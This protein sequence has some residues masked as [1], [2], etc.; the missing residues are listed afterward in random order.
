MKTRIFVTGASGFIGRNLVS[1]L[2]AHGYEVVA[3]SRK[4]IQIEG[5]QWFS[6]DILDAECLYRSMQGCSCVIHLAAVTPYYKINLS[7]IDAFNNYIQGIINIITAFDKVDAYT[8]LFASSGKVYGSSA[9]VPFAEDGPINPSS[10]MGKLKAEAERILQLYCDIARKNCRIISLR[11]FNA[12]GPGQSTDFLIPKLIKHLLLGS[13]K[14][15]DISVKRDYIHID[16]II[17][18]IIILL[19]KAPEGFIA[20]NVGSGIAISIAEIIEILCSLSKKSLKVEIDETQ[21][22]KEEGRVEQADIRRICSLGWKPLITIE[23]GLYDLLRSEF[24]L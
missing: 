10:L 1:H 5:V 23:E 18:S 14:L 20:Y 17:K 6:G 11:L 24:K 8:L 7:P 3:F 19:D 4:P 21:F 16:D 9:L 12:Y 13:V 15:G 2:I 22:R